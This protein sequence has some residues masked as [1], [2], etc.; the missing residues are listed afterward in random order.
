MSVALVSNA[1]LDDTSA[2]IRSKPVPWEVWS[3]PFLSSHV[4]YNTC[5]GYQR[6]GLVTSDE[7]LMIKRV[8]R[9]PRAKTE[10]VLLSDGQAYALLYLRLLKKLERADTVQAI[11]VLIA[12]ALVGKFVC[13]I[14]TH[15]RL[16]RIR[17]RRA[18]TIVHEDRGD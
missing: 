5:Q 3:R 6:A 11:L 16:I 17:S 12:D 4:N 2:K 14:S 9:Q 18:D 13:T 1:Y 10:S 7:L 15:T 8:D